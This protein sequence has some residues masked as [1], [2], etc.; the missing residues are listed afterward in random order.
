MSL[1]GQGK[2]N[3]PSLQTRDIVAEKLNIGSGKQY[4]K[5]KFITDN[6][7]TLSPTDFSEWDEGKLS[8][9]KAFMKIKNQL[10]EKVVGY[11]CPVLPLV[12]RVVLKKLI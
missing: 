4:E 7:N 11:S 3:F 12:L 10:Q 6:K 1:G 9:N 8:T 5:E 2:E